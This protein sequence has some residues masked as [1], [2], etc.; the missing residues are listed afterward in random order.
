MSVA[1]LKQVSEDP[2]RFYVFTG[3]GR[4]RLSGEN[5][6]ETRFALP[7]TLPDA[8]PVASLDCS[9][10]GALQLATLGSPSRAPTW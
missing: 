4:L 1:E 3:S 7:E 8:D 9:L 5:Q 2:R 6:G 10:K